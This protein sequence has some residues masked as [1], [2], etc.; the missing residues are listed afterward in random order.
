LNEQY[1]FSLKVQ[2]V[3]P[4][5]L[6][7]ICKEEDLLLALD[8]NQS[9]TKL[10]A[11]ILYFILRFDELKLSNSSIQNVFP[12]Y[13]RYQ[14]KRKAAD[15]DCFV[16]VQEEVTDKMS[17]FF[18]SP[19]PMLTVVLETM[20]NYMDNDQATA[21]NVTNCLM[22]LANVCKEMVATP[23]SCAKIESSGSINFVLRVMV[24]VVIMYDH[25]HPI[26]AYSKK[27]NIDIR[28]FIKVL[29]NPTH[30]STSEGLINCLRYRSKHAYAYDTPKNIKF[31]LEN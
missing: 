24:T 11:E 5:L 1:L 23:E 12:Y 26:G 28:G 15:P 14:S 10:L 18:A 16:P 13:R 6:D 8:S 21:E 31:L 22:I 30:V 7:Q 4:K 27:A 29:K 2:K 20:T 25:L 3:I 17:M 9:I 19:T